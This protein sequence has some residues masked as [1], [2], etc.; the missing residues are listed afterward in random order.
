VIVPRL[1]RWALN[2]L[3]RGFRRRYGNDMATMFEDTW[4]AGS[5]SDKVRVILRAVRD[6]T[7]S[8]IAL[9]VR[10]ED[11]WDVPRGLNGGSARRA[12]GN[13]TGRMMMGSGGLQDLRY[14]LKGLVA[15][16]GFAALTVLTVGLGVGASTAVFSVVD[17]V[18]FRA[19]PYEAPDDNPLYTVVGVVG[20]M[21]QSRLDAVP[22]PQIYLSLPQTPVPGRNW[23][24]RATVLV[25]GGGG[26]TALAP[27]IRRVVRELEPT[28]PV[29]QW[30]PMCCAA[31]ARACAF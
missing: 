5:V 31:L 8:A 30:W 17:A 9:R 29:W 24:R 4:V 3:P 28:V 22:S 25:R 7:V 6:L 19:L 10:A 2:V 11:D 12:Y 27:A 18:V 21:A 26:T 1:Y 15:R 16:P 23:V 13:G 14:A 20:D